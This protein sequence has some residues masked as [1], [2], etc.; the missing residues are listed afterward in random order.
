PAEPVPYG[1]SWFA[2][3]VLH[4]EPQAAIRTTPV[5]TLVRDLLFVLRNQQIPGPEAHA[6]LRRAVRLLSVVAEVNRLRA[7]PEPEPLQGPPGDQHR[8]IPSK[9]HLS[10]DNG[11]LLFANRWLLGTPYEV[12]RTAP[13]IALVEQLLDT[14]LDREIPALDALDATRRAVRLLAVFIA[15]NEHGQARNRHSSE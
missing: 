2:T 10:K 1:S 14:L 6:A 12:I 9:G 11:S 15:D 8:W 5:I 13:V 7:R 4:G 3:D